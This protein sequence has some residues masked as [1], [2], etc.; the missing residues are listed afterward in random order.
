[1]LV[2]CMHENCCNKRWQVN[3]HD[4]LFS[5]NNKNNTNN[6]NK[7][8]YECMCCLSSEQIGFSSQKQARYK[9]AVNN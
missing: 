7:N 8:V 9:S 5:T 1:M 4:M 2:F 6:V 3:N